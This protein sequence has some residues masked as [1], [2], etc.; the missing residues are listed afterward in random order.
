MD[1]GE[2]FSSVHHCVFPSTYPCHSD[3]DD[4]SLTVII[5]CYSKYVCPV[6][7]MMVLFTVGND[8]CVWHDACTSFHKNPLF[9][10][11]AIGWALIPL[12]GIS[13]YTV[14]LFVIFSTGRRTG[15]FFIQ[16]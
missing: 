6:T 4:V 11:D 2:V 8:G 7:A 5:K 13:L 14:S 15:C 1:D 3:F 12:I 16:I 10:S 9:D